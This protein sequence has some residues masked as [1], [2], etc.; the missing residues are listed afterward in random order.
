MPLERI[1]E[2]YRP[3]EVEFEVFKPGEYKI[4]GLRFFTLDDEGAP[5]FIAQNGER[6]VARFR[7][8]RPDGSDGPPGSIDRGM[9]S[10]LAKA[11]G[12]DPL[13]LPPFEQAS[14]RLILLERLANERAKEISVLVAEGGWISRIPGMELPKGFFRFQCRGIVSRNALGEPSWIEGQFG[15]LVVVEMEV[16]SDSLGKPSPYD[17][18]RV[19]EF[20]PY[21]LQVI[22]G[23]LIW[24]TREGGSW[25]SASTTFNNFLYSICGEDIFSTEFSDLDNIMPEVHEQ[26]QKEKRIC[27]GIVELNRRNR[28]CIRLG[29]LSS[30]EEMETPASEVEEPAQPL[31]RAL[32]DLFPGQAFRSDGSLTQELRDWWNALKGTDPTDGLTIEGI[33]SF[34]AKHSIPNRFQDMTADQVGLILRWMGETETRSDSF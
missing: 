23:Q 17:H 1:P 32:K 25:T 29:S 30:V 7:T 10:L 28:V 13:E 20:L 2:D 3:P 27:L 21:P 11:F 22:D 33:R 24:E 14:Q 6:L 9:E 34:T 4:C 8:I 15:R 18:V 19:R 16:V 5:I 26:I 31:L 12:L